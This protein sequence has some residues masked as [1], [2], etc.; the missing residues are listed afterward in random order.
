VSLDGRSRCGIRSW[1]ESSGQGQVVDLEASTPK[2]ATRQAFQAYGEA[3]PP[4]RNANRSVELMGVQFASW[5]LYWTALNVDP[6]QYAIAQSSPFCWKE[7]EMPSEK[8]GFC[9]DL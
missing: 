6:E 1:S 2:R 4:Y 5:K 8:V 7:M 3:S 9:Q